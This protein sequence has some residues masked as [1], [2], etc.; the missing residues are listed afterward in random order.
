MAL[1][2][3]LTKMSSSATP[4]DPEKLIEKPVSSA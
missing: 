1:L 3:N 2:P 4:A